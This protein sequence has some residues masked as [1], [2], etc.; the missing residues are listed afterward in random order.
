MDST[1]QHVVKHDGHPNHGHPPSGPQQPIGQPY[2]CANF[3][4]PNAVSDTFTYDTGFGDT[5]GWGNNELENYTN[6]PNNSFYRGDGK[7]VIR[8]V[9]N[10]NRTD[11]YRVLKYTSARLTTKQTLSKQC[12]FVAAVLTPPCASGVWPAFWMLPKAPFSWP[13]QGEVDIFESWNGDLINHSSLHWGNFDTADAKKHRTIETSTPGMAR[14]EG[15]MYGFAWDQKEDKDGSPGRLVWYV[16]WKPVMKA[17]IPLGT[18]RMSNYSI[19]FNIAMGGN[20][21]QNVTPVDGVYELVVHSLELYE[22]PP[23]GWGQ[24]NNDYH[25]AAEGK[26]YQP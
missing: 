4:P 13:T 20:V 12:G 6:D 16:D 26:Y 3:T 18:R 8:A 25:T 17:D 2:W 14:P 11:P 10:S 5:P 15:H 9:A 24:F 21:I 19:I 7:L 23:G 1:S 22:A